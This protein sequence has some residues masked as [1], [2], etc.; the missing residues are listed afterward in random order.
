MDVVGMC[1]ECHVVGL[2][3]SEQARGHPLNFVERKGPEVKECL[4][5]S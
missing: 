1:I 4:Y 2:R 5:E 3:L